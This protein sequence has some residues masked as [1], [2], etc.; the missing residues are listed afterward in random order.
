MTDVLEDGTRFRTFNVIDDYNRKVLFIEVDYTLKSSRVIWVLRHLV[1]KYCKPR[2]IRVDNG[3][4]FIAALTKSWSESLQID[5]KYIKPGKPAQN[6][7]VERFNRSYRAGVL[8]VIIFKNKN[9]VRENID[10][11][12][13]DYNHMRPHDSLG[14]ISPVDYRDRNLKAQYKQNIE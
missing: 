1:G 5:F 8:D 7:N 9:E 3:P 13:Y 2:K 10:D 6:A 12:L 14:G 4:E 11:W